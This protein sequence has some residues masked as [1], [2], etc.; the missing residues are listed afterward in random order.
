MQRIWTW[1]GALG[2][3]LFCGLIMIAIGIGA[4]I[5]KA[6]DPIAKPLVCE[7]GEL[8]ITQN[9]T[10]Y[11]AG[12]SEPWTTD[13]CVD[14]TTGQ[15]QDVSLQTTITAG[16]IYSLGIFVIIFVGAGYYKPKASIHSFGSPRFFPQPV[17]IK[18]DNVT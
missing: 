16:V 2:I 9:T 3:S 18:K 15:Q 12:E 1:V 5:P 13:T 11:R 4:V 17:N 14:S 8:Q 6:I 7:N 10:S